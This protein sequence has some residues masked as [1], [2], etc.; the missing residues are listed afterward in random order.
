[1]ADKMSC[2][3][4][5]SEGSDLL[6]HFRETGECPYCQADLEFMELIKQLQNDH[7]LELEEA[8]VNPYATKIEDPPAIKKLIEMHHEL[9]KVR[10]L[11][12]VLTTALINIEDNVQAAKG[13]IHG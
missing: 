3:V 13:H 7:Y 1:M 5:D 10:K 6:R 11:S 9:V 2:P 12:R 4:C 8:G